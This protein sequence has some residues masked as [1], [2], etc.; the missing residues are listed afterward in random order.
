MDMF[1]DKSCE[2]KKI[3][4]YFVYRLIKSIATFYS[5]ECFELSHNHRT[6]LKILI[7]KSFSIY[8][9]FK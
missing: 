3:I 6:Y 7:T 1:I 8:L 5:H 4:N 2:Y 9:L